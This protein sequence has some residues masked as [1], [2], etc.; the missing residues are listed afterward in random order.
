MV[1][2]DDREKPEQMMLR[3]LM[4]PLSMVMPID[5]LMEMAALPIY[6][7]VLLN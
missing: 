6:L 5:F 1:W 3:L 2:T 7:V 4:S